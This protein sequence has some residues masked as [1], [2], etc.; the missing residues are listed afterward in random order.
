MIGGGL[1]LVVCCRGQTRCVLFVLSPPLVTRRGPS[2]PL[3]KEKNCVCNLY[4]PPNEDRCPV[5]RPSPEI[6]LYAPGKDQVVGERLCLRAW[7]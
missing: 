3:S 5:S 2:L 7:Y 6:T 1:L 4:V